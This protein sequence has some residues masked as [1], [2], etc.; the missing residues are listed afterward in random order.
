MWCCSTLPHLVRR[1]T[2]LPDAPRSAPPTWTPWNLGPKPPSEPQ[3]SF[4]N[5]PRVPSPRREHRYPEIFLGVFP[6][7]SQIPAGLLHCAGEQFD[8]QDP[9]TGATISSCVQCK[10]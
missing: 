9:R 1:N 8:R 6:R 7:F 10:R 2:P 4:R 5:Y 3:T